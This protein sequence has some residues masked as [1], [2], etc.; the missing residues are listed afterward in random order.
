MRNLYRAVKISQSN[1]FHSEEEQSVFAG[2]SFKFYRKR[3]KLSSA[4]CLL[5]LEIRCR[6]LE[7]E[8]VQSDSQCIWLIRARVEVLISDVNVP[9][10]HLK[11]LHH[12]SGEL[13]S[14]R[15]A[16]LVFLLRCITSGPS[17]YKTSL[18]F[19][20]ATLH[21]TTTMIRSDKRI[22]IHYPPTYVHNDIALK[23]ISSYAWFHQLSPTM[24]HSGDFCSTA[25]FVSSASFIASILVNCF[26]FLSRAAC[27]SFASS[28][29]CP[30]N[31]Q[32][33]N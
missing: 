25:P 31:R 24:H 29:S 23:I 22:P 10:L 27:S 28:Y 32:T 11:V 30:V 1:L 21:N 12:L 4:V 16:L 20:I 2:I 3:N 13:L 5:L 17:R 33:P 14:E 19:I 8:T 18:I 26:L 6:Y 9:N 15:I 7:V